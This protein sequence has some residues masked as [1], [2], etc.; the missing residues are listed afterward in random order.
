M[1]KW[2]YAGWFHPW[3]HMS[4]I[5]MFDPYSGSHLRMITLPFSIWIIR[6]LSIQNLFSV[7]TWHRIHPRKGVEVL[8]LSGEQGLGWFAVWRRPSALN[9][10]W[11]WLLLNRNWYWSKI[12]I[13]VVEWNHMSSR[14]VAILS[15]PRSQD[16]FLVYI[17]YFTT[18]NHI[19]CLTFRSHF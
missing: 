5:T 10:H 11:I 12:G 8:C 7:N 18:H 15:R 19:I 4:K 9:A 17:V 3:I 14:V 13:F 1:A 6:T 16:D 2:T